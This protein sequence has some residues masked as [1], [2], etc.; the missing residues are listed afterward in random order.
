MY[1]I[2]W[3]YHFGI[4]IKRKWYFY[5]ILN[6]DTLLWEIKV[7]TLEMSI[8]KIQSLFTLN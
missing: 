7:I 5:Q 3:G 6:F 8:L 1:Q 4:Q 2:N